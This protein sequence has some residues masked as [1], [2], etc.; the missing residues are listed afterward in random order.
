MREV[1]QLIPYS[2]RFWKLSK[3]FKKPSKPVPVLKDGDH[4]FLTNEQ[5]V[6]KL[7]YQFECVHNFNLNVMSPIENEVLQKYDQ[8]TT[9]EFL[10]EEVLESNLIEIRTIIKNLKN[11]KAPGD[12]G[13]FYILLKRLPESSLN[14]LVRI[15]NRCFELAYFPSKWINAKVT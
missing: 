8:I 1:E 13:I 14:F 15:F 4:I 6:Q 5:K 2:K 10:P 7:A 3:V 12:D 11:M 9:Q